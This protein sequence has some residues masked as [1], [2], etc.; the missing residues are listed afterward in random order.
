MAILERYLQLAF[1]PGKRTESDPLEHSDNDGEEGFGDYPT[2]NIQ[3]LSSDGATIAV[4]KLNYASN[5]KTH[6]NQKYLSTILWMK[7]I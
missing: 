6:F 5:C 3:K 4:A 7:T 2:N 1:L